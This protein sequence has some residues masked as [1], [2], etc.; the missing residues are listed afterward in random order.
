MSTCENSREKTALDLSHEFWSSVLAE[1]QEAKAKSEKALVGWA[2]PIKS[3]AMAVHPDQ[4]SEA[5]EDAKRKGVP[6]EFL[7][8]GRPLFT[9]SRH[10][11]RYARTYGFRHKGY[12]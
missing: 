4:V 11:R 6:T 2:R 12:C 1:H 10:F 5:R 8:D 3:D 9:S 7:P